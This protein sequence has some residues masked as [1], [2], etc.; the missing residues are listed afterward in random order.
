[1]KKSIRILGLFLLCTIFVKA[2]DASP[3][4]NEIDPTKPTNLYTQ[5][6]AAFEYQSGKSVDR[7]GVRFNVQKAFNPDNLLLLE[8]PL[9]YNDG[10]NKFGLSDIRVRYF[11]AVKRNISKTFIAIVPFADVSIP[12]GQYNN[13]L[14]TSNWSFAAGSVFGFVISKQLSLFPGASYVHITKPTTDLIPEAFK[15]NSDGIGLQFN[16][17]YSI[18]KKTFL[19]VNPTPTFLNTNGNWKSIWTGEVNLNRIIIPNKFKINAYWGPNFTTD[20]HILRLGG[21]I[22]L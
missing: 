14:G 3:L 13:G 10:T 12:T 20:I 6:N 9:L 21:T 2:Q 18:N 1:M 22:Y 11:T 5:V 4:K 17:S 7:Y 8:I 16:A 19:F 15:Y